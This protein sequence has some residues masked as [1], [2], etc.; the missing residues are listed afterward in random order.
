MSRH[1][2]QI[3]WLALSLALVAGC[4]DSS[5]SSIVGSGGGDLTAAVADI[6][7]E[8][9]GITGDVLDDG[10]LSASKESSDPS[11]TITRTFEATRSCPAGGEVFV[12]G[13]WTR[14][15]IRATR[16]VEIVAFGG[17]TATDCAF[18]REDQTITV[19]GTSEW[20]K[21]RRRVSGKPDGLQTA[22][23]AGT[24]T[25]ESTTG[26][27]RVCNFNLSVVRDP[28]AGTVTIEGT[29]CDEQIRRVASWF[30]D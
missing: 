13:E 23:Y 18:A 12:F 11:V 29:L 26:E 20:D 16:E 9:D 1:I 25:A 6:A 19:N 4:S 5:P 8:L 27:T 15:E 30:G 3:G 21:F 28:D 14:T 2:K 10:T 22:S 7:L 17:R 24:W